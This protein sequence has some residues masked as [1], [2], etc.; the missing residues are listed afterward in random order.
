VNRS[1]TTPDQ[2]VGATEALGDAP[3][4]EAAP[5]PADT[6]FEITREVGRGGL[7][8]VS[9]SVAVK[10]LLAKGGGDAEQ[11]FLREALVIAR[12]Q[13]PS[14]IPIYETSRWLDGRPFYSMKLVSGPRPWPARPPTAIRRRGCSTSGW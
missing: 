7:G 12:L 3:P 2:G 9:R 4:P 14:I 6:R 11:R 8:R 10:E 5:P 13:H 1:E